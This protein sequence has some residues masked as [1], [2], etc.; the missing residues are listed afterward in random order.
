MLHLSQN[1]NQDRNFQRTKYNYN[2]ETL[3]NNM[4]RF[5]AFIVIPL[6]P[7]GD[8]SGQVSQEILFWQHLTMK[9]MYQ[10]IGNA[11]QVR[12]NMHQSNANTN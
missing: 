5:R 11:L 12:L 8:P 9:S 6:Y 4:F 3:K 1:L 10:I 7:E 2:I